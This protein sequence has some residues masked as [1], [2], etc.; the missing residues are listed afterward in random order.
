[1]VTSLENNSQGLK[2]IADGITR[3]VTPDLEPS[4]QWH[5]THFP[6]SWA[7]V[8]S[9]LEWRLAIYGISHSLSP[10]A[11][12]LPSAQL[13]LWLYFPLILSRLSALGGS[14]NSALKHFSQQL[15]GFDPPLFFHSEN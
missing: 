2:K 3:G 9:V 10:A 8:N 11:L 14:I 7:P 4:S 6:W 15:F 5:V 13:P 12:Q 1:M